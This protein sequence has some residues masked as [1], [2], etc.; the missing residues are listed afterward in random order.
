MTAKDLNLSLD[1]GLLQSTRSR[2]S[3][4]AARAST[5]PGISEKVAPPT[6]T[7]LGGKPQWKAAAAIA[8]LNIAII[9]GAGYWLIE[10][11]NMLPKTDRL[12]SVELNQAVRTDLAEL[13]IQLS[14]LHDEVQS[15]KLSQN[16]QRELIKSSLQ[17]A[18]LLREKAQKKS[19]LAK[20]KPAEVAT[21]AEDKDWYVNLGSFTS[22]KEASGLQRKMLAIGYQPQIKTQKDQ[23]Q[24]THSVVL[25]G[26]KNRKSAEVAAKLLMEQTNL[27]SL[28]VWQG[29]T[30]G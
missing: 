5:P 26:F 28:W 16:E 14:A 17:E 12:A 2:D 27:D 6:A 19:N 30:E 21:L 4:A 15:L 9:L 24:I 10:H 18:Q 1:P 11:S 23:D 8:L 7:P 13:N 3:G 20:E 29:N 25:S 22:A